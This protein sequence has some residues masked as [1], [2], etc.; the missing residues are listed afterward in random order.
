MDRVMDKQCLNDNA[1]EQTAEERL[2]ES[3]VQLQA[4]FDNAF[5]GIMLLTGERLIARANDRVAQIL[6]YRDPTELIGLSV[7]SLH[8]SEERFV[9][10]GKR[11]FEPLRNRE[12]PHVEYQLR[13]RD[14]SPFYCSLSGRALDT[15]VPADL[16]KGA[17][18]ILDDIDELKRIERALR[19]SEARYR[20]LFESASEGMLIIRDSRF[21][22]ANQAAQRMLGLNLVDGRCDLSPAELSPP[23]QPDGQ[24][25]AVKAG[26]LIELTLQQG[27]H[28]FEWEHQRGD[29]GRFQV[30]V[31]LSRV[32]LDDKDALLVS[33]Y[34]LSRQHQIDYLSDHD[35]LTNLPNARLLRKRLIQTLNFAGFANAR[36]AVLTLDLD[37]FKHVMDSHRHEVW[38]QVLKTLASRLVANSP[39][40]TIVA[41]ISGDVFTLVLENAV[42]SAWTTQQAR[43]I[44]DC[45]CA[46]LPLL[47]GGE[48]CMTV[49]IGVALYPD[50][51]H[52]AIE[53]LRDAGSA[54]HAAKR[55]GPGSLAFYTP[56]MTVSS[57]N[58]LQ[59]LQ[60]LRQA[61]QED[62]FVLHYQPKIDLATATIIGGEALIRWRRPDGAMISPGDF[63]PLV[64]TTDLVH[65]VGQWVLRT[66]L[67]QMRIWSAASLPPQQVSINIAGPQ[68]ASET[69]PDEIAAMLAE[70]GIAPH[71][72]QIELLESLLLDDPEK[73]RRQLIAIRKLGVTVALDDFGTGYSSLAYLS[74]FPVDILKI[75]RSFVNNLAEDAGNLAIIRATIAMAHGLG[76]RVVAEGVETD[77]QIALLHRLGCDLVQGYRTGRPM[78]AGDFARL[79]AADP[80]TMLPPAL[81]KLTTQGVLIVEDDPVQ[82]RL[83]S[84][85]LANQG[86]AIFAVDCA[87]AVWEILADEQI[88]LLIADYG[89]PGMDGIT[90][91]E[92][93]RERHP[94]IVRIML[95]AASEAAIP[96][97]AINRGGVFRYL[98]KPCRTED[99]RAAAHEGV[100]LA[101][102]LRQTQNEFA[103]RSEMP[104]PVNRG[105]PRP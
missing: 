99:L 83:L 46:P 4:I 23:Y 24:E 86:L 76:I 6:G 74:G 50:D 97:G 34:D 84:A 30:E 82:R 77:A 58:R 63:I 38:E 62:E 78:P 2:R 80:V 70:T 51:A 85:Q 90:L 59:L 19:E 79:I 48:L 32:R 15:A 49:C 98:T 65:P 17:I 64:E 18:W 66:A 25:S 104:P 47:N 36:V 105:Q 93:T 88:Y 53:L 102:M 57:A 92:Q 43:R 96:S 61:L 3:E 101:R 35:Q 37:G 52:D 81:I 75:D 67:H 21:V 73:A 94:D 54:L 56:E 91:M 89:L 72:F 33:W 44:Q 22:S 26:Q 7:R 71:L 14:G 29:G 31:T 16:S 28:R 10:F 5:V 103:P 55:A 42:D 20:A 12:Q 40:A 45:L 100:Q 68:F 1:H 13:R 95:S 11:F 8:L 60:Q 39:P 87:E 27:A 41:R 9:E 69:L